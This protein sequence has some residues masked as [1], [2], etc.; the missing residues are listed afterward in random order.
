MTELIDE[1]AERAIAADGTA[2]IVRVYG[3]PRPDGTWIGWLEFH[4]VNGA[5]PVLRTDQETTQPDRAALL[6]W[7]GRLTPVY[8]EGALHYRA[9]P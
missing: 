2:Y 8:V 9:H 4:P 3:A 1:H 5:S 7:A 6:Y